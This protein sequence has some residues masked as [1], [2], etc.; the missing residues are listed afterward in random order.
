[1]M[2]T[3]EDAIHEASDKRR[4]L[5]IY[6]HDIVKHKKVAEKFLK[7]TVACNEALHMLVIALN[8]I[9]QEFYY[10]RSRCKYRRR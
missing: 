5:L 3:L 7:N 6:I 10:I 8:I 9:G 4:P 1:M 2:G